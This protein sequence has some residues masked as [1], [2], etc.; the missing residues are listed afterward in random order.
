MSQALRR[1]PGL[2]DRAFIVAA[3]R[4]PGQA[5]QAREQQHWQSRERQQQQPQQQPQQRQQQQQEQP[6]MPQQKQQQQQQQTAMSQQ[7]QQQQ[8]D[9]KQQMQQQQQQLAMQQQTL[10]PPVQNSASGPHGD[11]QQQA[12]QLIQGQFRATESSNKGKEAEGSP[13]F[14]AAALPSSSHGVSSSNITGSNGSSGAVNSPRDA[15]RSVV[16]GIGGNSSSKGNSDS[17]SGSNSNSGSID[18]SSSSSCSS[19]SSNSNSS[20]SSSHDSSNSERWTET[21]SVEGPNPSGFC[22]RAADTHAEPNGLSVQG[23]WVPPPAR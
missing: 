20:S 10:Q 8:P 17:N 12:E 5:A 22:P 16:N 6:A 3:Q 11:A 4:G 1:E 2:T 14:G 19:D 18:S 13:T 23:D 15:D 9:V 7:Q 21:R